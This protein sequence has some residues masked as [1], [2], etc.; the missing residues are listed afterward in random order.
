VAENS[1]QSEKFSLYERLRSLNTSDF[2]DLVSSLKHTLSLRVGWPHAI[3]FFWRFWTFAWT[4]P[5]WAQ[6]FC[7]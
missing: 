1:M 4:L 3:W 7:L 2:Y 6:F 5:D